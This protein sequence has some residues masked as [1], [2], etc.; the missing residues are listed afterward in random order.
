MANSDNALQS[1]H[2][3]ANDGINPPSVVHK[4][5][6]NF[7]TEGANAAFRAGQPVE[8]WIG[9][10]KFRFFQDGTANM[11]AYDLGNGE[12]SFTDRQ[13]EKLLFD[14]PSVERLGGGVR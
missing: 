5:T 11:I 8:G 9:R 7:A 14:A 13:Q 3:C 4:P 12:V 10:V 1:L 2:R 6:F